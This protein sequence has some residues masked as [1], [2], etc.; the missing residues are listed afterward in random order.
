MT[1]KI[2]WW[3]ECHWFP[4]DVGRPFKMQSE[5]AS[6]PPVIIHLFSGAAQKQF[7]QR[8]R[9]IVQPQDR[10]SEK[11]LASCSQTDADSHNLR[12]GRYHGSLAHL[13]CHSFL[14]PCSPLCL[15]EHLRCSRSGPG[16][17]LW[18][19]VFSASN[20]S[21]VVVLTSYWLYMRNVIMRKCLGCDVWFR[22][23]VLHLPSCQWPCSSQ[24]IRQHA[25]RWNCCI[26]HTNLKEQVQSKDTGYGLKCALY[27]LLFNDPREASDMAALHV[28]FGRRCAHVVKSYTLFSLKNLCVPYLHVHTFPWTIHVCMA[29]VLLLWMTGKFFISSF[30]AETLPYAAH[31]NHM[32]CTG[33]SIFKKVTSLTRF[34]KFLVLVTFST[35]RK[36]RVEE[37]MSLNINK[38]V[39]INTV[40]VWHPSSWSLS[41]SFIS[42][43]TGATVLYIC[44]C[45]EN[46]RH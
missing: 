22:A 36:G 43:C 3:Y 38:A 23:L 13:L 39:I 28:R 9:L 11:R 42:F 14:P 12:L 1:C 18:P 17:G 26:E 6:V 24:L 44:L 32:L 5:H 16:S 27:G 15:N 45:W 7:E 40:Q 2:G 33:S 37:F 19:A 46:Q 4:A 21:C 34:F 25:W 20:G 8:L 30:L 10:E 41:P 35:V 29:W 31:T